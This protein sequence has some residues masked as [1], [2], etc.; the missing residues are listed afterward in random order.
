MKV[1][2][3]YLGGYYP[4]LRR[5]IFG[6]SQHVNFKESPKYYALNVLSDDP[7][8]DPLIYSVKRFE[9]KFGA[10]QVILTGGDGAFLAENSA[11]KNGHYEPNLVFI[12]LNQILN[13]NLSVLNK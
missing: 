4:L 10:L 1:D 13:Y 7:N 5:S 6:P 9:K 11:L 8:S 12:G 3:K 2:R